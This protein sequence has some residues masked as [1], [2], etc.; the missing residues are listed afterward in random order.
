MSSIVTF[1]CDDYWKSQIYEEKGN[2]N[3]QRAKIS[4]VSSAELEISSA[5]SNKTQLERDQLAKPLGKDP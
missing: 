3:A 5:Q 2:K 1:L 4:W